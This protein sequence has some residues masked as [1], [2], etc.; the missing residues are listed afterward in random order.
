MRLYGAAAGLLRGM[1]R[2]GDTCLGPLAINELVGQ[3]VV[4]TVRVGG[5]RER[6]GGGHR[7]GLNG[8]RLP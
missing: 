1:S 7:A 3:R 4:S 2:E 8:T 6:E 5:K